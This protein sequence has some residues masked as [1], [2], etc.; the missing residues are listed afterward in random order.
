[1]KRKAE[2]AELSNTIES[3]DET[4]ERGLEQV[5]RNDP[6]GIVNEGPT[7]KKGRFEMTETSTECSWDLGTVVTEYANK[8]MD[9]FVS[10]ETLINEILSFNLVPE[11]LKKGKIL[12]PYL[13][14]LLPEQDKYILSKP[15]QKFE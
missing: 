7:K 13:R 6:S 2:N 1:M 8:Y 4:P 3:K 9:N 10:N 15:G 12:D 11:N 14:K 5:G